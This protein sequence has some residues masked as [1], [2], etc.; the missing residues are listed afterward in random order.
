MEQMV[1][2]DEVRLNLWKIRLICPLWW[3][4]LKKTSRKVGREKNA[5]KSKCLESRNTLWFYNMMG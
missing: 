2:I 3:T 4:N 5:M 1:G